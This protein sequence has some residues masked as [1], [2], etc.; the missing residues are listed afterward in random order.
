MISRR[1]LLQNFLW[2]SGGL[3]TAQLVSSQISGSPTHSQPG[4]QIVLPP[5]KDVRLVVLSDLNGAYG[6]VTYDPEVHQAIALIQKWQPDL[7]ICGGDMVAGQS[8]QLSS[9]Q[10]QAMWKGFD[11]TLTQPLQT[12]KIPFGFTLGNHDGSGYQSL[13]GDYVFERDRNL[14]KAYWQ[15]AH[16]RCGLEFVDDQH[17]PFYYAFRQHNIFY[18]FW[19]ATTAKLSSTQL[20]W[21]EQTLAQAQDA[22]LRIVVGH[23]PLYAVAEGRNKAGEILNDAESLKALLIRH[24]VHTYIS[25]HHHAYYPGQKESLRFL[26]SGALGGGPRPLIGSQ[27]KPFKSITVVDV[28]LGR[29]ETQYSTYNMVTFEQVKHQILPAQITGI[30][31]TIQRQN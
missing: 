10:I 13:A 15:K 28:D 6:S 26:H 2:G 25:G 19:D 8:N 16:Q 12:A 11:Q 17:F 14:A 23:L 30:N 27:V 18:L 7:V 5:R 9:A 3:I 20:K 21:V 31:G 1:R 24:K 29:Q 4:P 22:A